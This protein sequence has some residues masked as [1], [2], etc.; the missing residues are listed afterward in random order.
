MRPVIF[1][2]YYD[3]VSTLLAAD[4]MSEALRERGVE[5]RSIYA[6]ELGGIRDSILIFIKTSKWHHLRPA[7][8]RGNILILDVHDKLVYRRRVK[9]R[10]LFH[11][12]IYRNRRQWHDF[13]C[14]HP[15]ATVI[16]LHWDPRFGPNEVG[17][18]AFKVGYLGNSRSFSLWDQLPGVPCCR[19]DAIF[20]SARHF[21]CHL[22]IRTTERETRYKP[23]VKVA[24]AAACEANIITTRDASAL[25]ILGPDYPYYTE[26][27]AESVMAA[28]EHARETFGT[29]V[30]RSGLEKMKE[31][32]AANSL[33]AEADKYLEYLRRFD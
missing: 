18:T 4:Q 17:A 16:H 11:G 28:I 13:S 26:P 7:R 30:W 12:V 1:V 21:N 32:K 27:D 8:W 10:R 33:D 15:G 20:E 23:T 29:A 9:N 2:K 24:T 3:R 14:N 25:E 6:H 22:S 5:S 31:I 19:N